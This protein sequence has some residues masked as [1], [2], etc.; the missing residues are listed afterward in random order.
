MT[1][2]IVDVAGRCPQTTFVI[3]GYSQG[4]S[5]TDI[6]IDARGAQRLGRGETIPAELAPRIAAVVVFG[7]PLSGFS[8]STL[9]NASALCRRRLSRHR[10]RPGSPGR[11]SPGRAAPSGAPAR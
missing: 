9:E 7:D 8:G 1:R 4:A 10:P 2:H 11:I 3:G 6:A 5:V